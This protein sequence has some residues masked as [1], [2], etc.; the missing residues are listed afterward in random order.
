LYHPYSYMPA[1]GRFYR[2]ELTTGNYPFVN[3]FLNFKVKRTRVFLMFDHLNAGKTGY[4]YDMIPGYPMNIRMFRYGLA[5][6]F[7]D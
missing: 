2:Q 5:W 4:N 1:T 6:T 3:V 7:Y